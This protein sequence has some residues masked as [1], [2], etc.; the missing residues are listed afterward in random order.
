MRGGVEIGKGLY[1]CVFNP[2]LKCKPSTKKSVYKQDTRIPPVSKI[3]VKEDGLRE[4]NATEILQTIP[5][6][7]SYFVAV[8]A[9]CEP[10]EP[11]KQSENIT[12]CKIVK[13]KPYSKLI[14]L[15]MPYS[16]LTL[17]QRRPFFLEHYMAFSKHLLEAGSY[18][19][20][21]QLVHFDMHLNNILVLD[22]PRLIDFGFLWSPNSLTYMNVS[23]QYRK[24]DPRLDQESADC[25]YWNGK[26]EKQDNATL[27]QDILKRKPIVQILQT[28]LGVS[29]AQL[30]K[31]FE[32][33]TM[34]S[35]VVKN[36]DSLNYFKLYWSKFDAWS[37]GAIIATFFYYGLFDP[38]F[39]TAV[40][41]V[42]KIKIITVCK[43][44]L[45]F[46]PAYRLDAIEA[47]N[48]WA[49]ESPVLKDPTIAKW[50]ESQTALRAKTISASEFSYV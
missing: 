2:P 5:N 20:S 9:S 26:L 43:G 30:E 28:A 6:F 42:N 24:Y 31:E 14:L 32:S 45:H 39:K 3:T 34:S 1:G 10:E 23:N 19:L 41:D 35:A 37:I 22:K 16:G 47:L 49:P 48:L 7:E 13:Q 25:T 11:E 8:S 46:D 18:L 33:F 38:A 4:I 17:N 12:E 27:I 15:T 36:F 44:L 40:Y 50:L 21:K 29:Y